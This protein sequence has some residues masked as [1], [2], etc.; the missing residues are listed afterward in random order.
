MFEENS[1]VGFKESIEEG[2]DDLVFYVVWS[3]NQRTCVVHMDSPMTIKPTFTYPTQ[4]LV[5]L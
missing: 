3:D 2:D 4:D 5:S 1:K